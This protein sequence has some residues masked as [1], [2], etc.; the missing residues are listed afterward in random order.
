[1]TEFRWLIF[2]LAQLTATHL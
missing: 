2:T 1:M